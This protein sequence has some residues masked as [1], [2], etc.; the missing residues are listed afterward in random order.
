MKIFSTLVFLII[1]TNTFANES[2][3]EDWMKKMDNMSFEEAKKM[4]L[5]M[6]DNKSTMM[7]QERKC[8]VATNDKSAL[9]ECM[10]EMKD[11]KK[12]MMDKVKK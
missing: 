3:H 12:E 7:E 4:K 10:T 2:Y 9:R 8:V 1:C 11:M 6:L 5:E